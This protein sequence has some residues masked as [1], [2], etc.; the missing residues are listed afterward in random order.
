MKT[1]QA[2][3]RMLKDLSTTFC[4][5]TLRMSLSGNRSKCTFRLPSFWCRGHKD[6]T[7]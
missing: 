7:G 1:W 3:S 2:Y 5:L 6:G 4:I